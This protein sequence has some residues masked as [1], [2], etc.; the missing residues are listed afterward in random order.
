M[1]VQDGDT[2]LDTELVV[3][4]E[5]VSGVQFGFVHAGINTLNTAGAPGATGVARSPARS[6]GLTYV[7]G[8]GGITIPGEPGTAGGKAGP[9]ISR[10]WIS[11]SDLQ[12]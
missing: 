10:P 3:G 5:P 2:G 12:R 7:G 6:A 9:P 4:G 11:L 8:N 1:W